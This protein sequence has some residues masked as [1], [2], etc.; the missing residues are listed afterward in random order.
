M[1]SPA[2]AVAEPFF[3]LIRLTFSPQLLALAFGSAAKSLS[4]AD[5]AGQQSQ[6]HASFMQSLN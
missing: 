1:A 6:F 3:E 5:T 4:F 2:R